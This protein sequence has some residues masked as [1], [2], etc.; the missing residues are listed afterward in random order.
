[1]TSRRPTISREPFIRDA[2]FASVAVGPSHDAARTS[3]ADDSAVD[4][5]E[6]QHELHADERAAANR[7]PE[8]RRAGFLAGRRALRA[9]LREVAP[10]S[11]NAA[12]LSTPRG[13]PQLP[14][15]YT[16]SISHKRSR[17]IALVAPSSG[18]LVGLDLEER[19]QPD[20]VARPSIAKRI[21]TPDE[22]AAIAPLDALAHREATLVHFA[23]KEAV[24]KAI[25]PYVERYVRFT[26]VELAVEGDGRA[27]V[28]LLLPELAAGEIRV[29]AR[30]RLDERWIIAMARSSRG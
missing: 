21:L 18:E 19:P 8:S 9:A 7:M 26:E 22:Q 17:A 23:L 5:G 11:A 13:A 14:A 27:T 3:D 6:D 25:D 15:G 29:E 4:Q 16:G 10:G 12:M 1:M 24:Y 28:R 20:D 30:W 2:A